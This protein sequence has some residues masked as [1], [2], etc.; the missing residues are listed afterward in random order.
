MGLRDFLGV[1]L[2]LVPLTPGSEAPDQLVLYAHPGQATYGMWPPI[3]LPSPRWF[4]HC[5]LANHWTEVARG[6]NA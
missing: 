4:V 2:A 5:L 3:A 1:I 6:V